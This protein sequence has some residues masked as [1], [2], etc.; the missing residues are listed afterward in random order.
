MRLFEKSSD[1]EKRCSMK[2]R[3]IMS[4]H[5]EKIDFDSTVSEA[6]EKMMSSDIG[7]LPVDKGGKIVGMVTDRDIAIRAIAQ[8]LNPEKTPV[9]RIMSSDV[10][11]CYDDDDIEDAESKMEE[12]QVRRLLVLNSDNER[13]VGI[14]SISDLAVKASGEKLACKALEKICEPVGSRW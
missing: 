3:E 8:Y 14:L 1:Q 11:Y 10:V 13:P 7:V 6:A 4:S 12:K 9:S 2:V 5:C